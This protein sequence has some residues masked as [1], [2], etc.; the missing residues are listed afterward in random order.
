[1]KALLKFEMPSE[2]TWDCPCYREDEFCNGMCTEELKLTPD[3]GRPHW[4]PLIRFLSLLIGF[5]QS[6]AFMISR[7]VKSYSREI[8]MSVASFYLADHLQFK[9]HIPRIN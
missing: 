5:M 2:C 4:C 1:M 7:Q 6:T 3:S 9:E 8:N